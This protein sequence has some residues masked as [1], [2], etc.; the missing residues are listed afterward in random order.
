MT[1]YFT[2]ASAVLAIAAAAPAVNA[3]VQDQGSVR[4]SYADLNLASVSGRQALDHRVSRAID[5]ACGE[6]PMLSD[7]DGQHA[8]Q[9]CEKAARSN[10]ETQLKTVTTSVAD[11][12]DVALGQ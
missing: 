3:Q 5:K 11:I 4:V 6:R 8:F 9:S 1:R 7:L 2:L 10:V 12:S